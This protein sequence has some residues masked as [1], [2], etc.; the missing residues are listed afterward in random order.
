[1]AQPVHNTF[2]TTRVVSS[3]STETLRKR[4]LEF[5][6]THRFGD[7]A[8]PLGG[9]D[10]WYGF[11]DA[12]DIR[13]AFEYGITN[14]LMV[15]IARDKGAYQ[16]KALIDGFAKYRLLTQTE[17]KSMP[18]SLA[19]NLAGDISTM[20]RSSD[21]TKVTS[22]P[23]FAHRATYLVQAIIAHKFHER[24][25]LELLPTFLH[26]NF[27]LAVEQNDV[28]A[29]GAAFRFRF[30]KMMA[31][32]VD[33]Y[34]PLTPNGGSDP[35]EVYNHPLGIGF[36]LETG[37]HVFT[38]NFTNSEGITENQFIPEG[39]SNWLDGEF[40]IGFTIARKFKI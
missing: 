1:M 31:L 16:R 11:D 19:L 38:L 26:R 30:Y 21:S 4:I 13:F 28:F 2:T 24:F 6:I 34:Y 18:V 15:G 40:R 37:G 20:N 17:N 29:L 12:R 25:S 14:E 9:W 5:R 3:Q 27:V 36:E 23:L 32:L 22:F 8:G 10:N 35:D 33:Y 7:I 39:S